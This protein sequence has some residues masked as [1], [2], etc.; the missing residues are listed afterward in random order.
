MFSGTNMN[1]SPKPC[2]MLTHTIVRVA[3]SG[4][5]SIEKL[6]ETT[7]QERPVKSRRRG[8][9]SDISRP[10]ISMET[11]MPTPRVPSSMPAS[12]MG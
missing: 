3:V 10:A 11:P 6:S 5:K 12:M 1:P 9:T 4:V 8:S 2:S 7:Q